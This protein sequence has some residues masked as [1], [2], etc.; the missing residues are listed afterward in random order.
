MLDRLRHVASQ[1]ETA[2][3]LDRRAGRSASPALAEVLRE[4]AARRRR[5][6]ERVRAAALAGTGGS[7]QCAGT[8]A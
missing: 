8:A 4:G 2:A 6:A 5:S 3:V 1:L 7:S